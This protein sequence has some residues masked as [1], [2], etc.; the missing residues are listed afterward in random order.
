LIK[1]P[2]SRT[3]EVTHPDNETITA[4]PDTESNAQMIFD[5]WG[6]GTAYIIS[7]VAD[8]FQPNNN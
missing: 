5:S 2:I 6:F 3:G 7:S 4:N 8:L 1:R